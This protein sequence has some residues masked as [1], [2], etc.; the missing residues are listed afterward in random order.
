M[1][2]ITFEHH[3]GDGIS[4]SFD[5]RNV[6]NFF[7][8]VGVTHSNHHTMHTIINSLEVPSQKLLIVRKEMMIFTMR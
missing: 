2:S 3:W 1:Y 6:M 4:N 7:I 5:L 8:F